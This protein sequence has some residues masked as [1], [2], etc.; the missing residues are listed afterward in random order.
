MSYTCPACGSTSQSAD[1]E[2]N[3][4]C[5]RCH[6]FEDDLQLHEFPR[7]DFEGNGVHVFSPAEL[8]AELESYLGAVDDTVDAITD[9]EIEERLRGTLAAV[10][11]TTSEDV[12]V[13]HV[14]VTETA[15][16]TMAGTLVIRILG[17][18]NQ[19]TPFDGQW[20]T[21]Y[22]PSRAGVDPDGKPMIAHLRTSAD[23]S[24]AL[25]FNGW[26]E[27][28]ALWSQESGHIRPDGQKDR[29]LTAFAISIEPADD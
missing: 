8:A 20:L 24:Q 6:R 22:D 9:Q 18:G 17:I 12:D 13:S 21:E 28:H 1:D 11:M 5:G 2:R 29:P 27:A 4:Y 16:G 19:P 15:A 3:R 14:Q 7:D 25:R 10:G 23:K 26:V